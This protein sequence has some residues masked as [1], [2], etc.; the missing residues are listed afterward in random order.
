MNSNDILTID[1]IYPITEETGH[2]YC[3]QE[4]YGDDDYC[5]LCSPEAPL[6]ENTQCTADVCSG[7]GACF[8]DVE[9]TECHGCG[10]VPTLESNCYEYATQLECTGGQNVNDVEGSIE[11]SQDQ[12]SWGVCSWVSGTNSPVDGFCFKDGNADTL[13]DCSMFTAGEYRSCTI[14][15]ESPNT[16]IQEE[17]IH[18][19]VWNY[20]NCKFYFV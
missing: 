5:S 13:D 17:G 7:L 11:S 20:W 18:K 2:G 19:Y 4:E 12:C 14:D 1:P 10:D 16:K 15:I 6:F 3:V 9:L 8:S